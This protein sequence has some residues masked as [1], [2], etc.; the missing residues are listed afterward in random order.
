MDLEGGE[1]VTQLLLRWR[2]GD[3]SALERLTPLVYDELHRRARRCLRRER[4]PRA[5]QTTELLNETYLRLVDAQRVD[6]QD[7]AHFYAIAAQLMRRVLV[8][9]ARKRKVGK[10]GGGLTRV[11]LDEHLVGGAEQQADLVALDDA[12]RTLEEFAPGKCRVVELRFFGGLTI[13]E[14]AAV[15]GVSVDAVKREWRTAK[16]W[17]LEVLTR[18]PEGSGRDGP[19]ALATD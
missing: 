19:A 9:E 5:L 16:L 18:P 15:L 7:R 1:S 12:L 3:E 2:G 10:R 11:T 4:G 14:A 13:A 6:W 17:L 8:D